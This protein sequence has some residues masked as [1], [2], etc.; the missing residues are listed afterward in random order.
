MTEAVIGV[1]NIKKTYGDTVAVKGVTFDVKKGEVFT[2]LGPNGAGKTTLMEIIEG[3]RKADSGDISYF[4][5]KM[6]RVDKETKERIGVLLQSTSFI[7][8]LKVGEAISLFASFFKKTLRREDLLEF[9]SLKEKVNA[10]VDKLS[11]GQKQRVA[12][13]CALVND[14]DVVFLDE[15]STGLDPQARRNVWKI[16]NNLKERGKTVFLTTHYMDEAQELSDRVYIMDHGQVIA[17][18]TPEELIRSLGE[19]GFIEFETRNE[20]SESFN[21][22]HLEGISRLN[23]STRLSTKDL[24]GTLKK[25]MKWSIDKNYRLSGIKVHQPDLEDVFLSLTGRRLRD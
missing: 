13:A 18:G 10:P 25:L 1:K 22:W 11:G 9:I 16:I 4:G 8:N 7:P 19:I 6:N 20:I 23:G 14:P 3:I 15:P 24:P 5:R 2:L 12:I 21:D 17:N